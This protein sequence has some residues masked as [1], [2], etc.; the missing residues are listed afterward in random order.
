MNI[1][2]ENRIINW[3]DIETPLGTLVYCGSLYT[4]QI[5]MEEFRRLEFFS[6]SILIEGGGRYRDEQGH[7]IRL[8]AGDCIWVTPG[9]KHMYGCEQGDTWTELYLCFKGEPFQQWTK[10]ALKERPVFHLGDPNIWFPRWSRILKSSPRNHAEAVSTLA[11]IHLLLND[12]NAAD[13]QDWSFQERLEASKHHLQSWPSA[14]TPDWNI[15][16]AEC[17]CS[18]ETWRK[19]FRAHFDIAP[20]Q[21]RRKHLMEQAALM[22]TRSALSNEQ[23]ADCFGCSDGFHFSKLF[24]SIMG[25]TPNAYRQQLK[26]A[27]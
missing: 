22:M 12:I 13:Q 10:R 5:W 2:R 9:V 16:A 20:A 25:I 11:K 6:F 27:L 3:I 18:Y 4:E 26:E 19:A 21:Y 15:L 7:D 24:K 1:P 8:R 23:L 17:G 14:Q